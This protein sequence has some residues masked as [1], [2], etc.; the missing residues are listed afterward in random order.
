[1]HTEG[2]ANFIGIETGDIA[3]GFY[4][5]MHNLGYD[6]SVLDCDGGTSAE[7]DLVIKSQEDLDDF[8]AIID[9]VIKLKK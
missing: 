8:C 6:I 3:I 2:Y 5:W 7:S 9:L 1:M 4:C